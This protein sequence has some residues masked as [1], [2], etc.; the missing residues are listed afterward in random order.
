L[1]ALKQ[2]KP[3]KEKSKAYST[4]RFYLNTKYNV[5]TLSQIKFRKHSVKSK[6]GCRAKIDLWEGNQTGTKV[7]RGGKLCQGC[8]RAHCV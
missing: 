6:A 1:P 2:I 3:T 8:R 4:D 7:R 5:E